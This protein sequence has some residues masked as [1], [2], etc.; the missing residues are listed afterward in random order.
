[1]RQ[2]DRDAG[3]RRLVAGNPPRL[4]PRHDHRA[5]S[6]SRAARSASS[7]T[8]RCILAARSTASAADKAARFMQLCDAHDVP[9]LSCTTPP[10][11]WSARS[12]EDRAGP[13]LLPLPIWSAPMSRC[14]CSSVM[15]RKSYGLGKLAMTGGGFHAVGMFARLVANRRVRRHGSGRARSSSAA[16]RNSR[17]SKIR[18]SGWRPTSAWS[19]TSTKAARRSTPAVCSNVDDVIDPA[20]TRRW[21]VAGLRS[22]P[23]TPVREGKR[24]PC[25]DGW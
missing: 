11:T 15:T 19:R 25:V 22:V 16:A 10:A 18:P 23:P 6:A 3:R 7:P 14:R 8:I 24:R 1:M 5:S 12:G 2:R 9:L 13:P 20:E 21:I 17:P 4:W